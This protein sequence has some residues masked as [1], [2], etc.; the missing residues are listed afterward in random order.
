MDC[1]QFDRLLDRLLDGA[2]D[3]A[4]WRRAQAHLADCARCGRLFEALSGQVDT[5]DE[6]GHAALTATIVAR[7]SGSTCAACR[8]RLCDFVDGGI[9]ALDRALIET[10]LAGCHDCDALAGALARSTRV[11]P[12][13]IE[14]APP[15][16]FAGSVLAVTSR[17]ESEPSPGERLAAWLARAAARPRFSLEVAYVVTLL[18]ILLLGDP[19]KAVRGTAE[20]GVSY[21]QPHAGVIVQQLTARLAGVQRLGTETAGAVASATKRPDALATGWDAGVSAVRQWLFANVGA[22]VRALIERVFQWMRAV[23]DGLQGLVQK[24]LPATSPPGP[25]AS[26]AVRVTEP[27]GAAVRLT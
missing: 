5:L 21:V 16:S 14:I 18:L 24:R 17:R 25:P 3:G 10:H 26:K 20:R 13:F 12:S 19:V 7:T 9:A 6:A 2:C 15:A 27:S 11:L 22:P 1:H 8:D 4:E 23:L